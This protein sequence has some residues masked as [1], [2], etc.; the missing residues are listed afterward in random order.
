MT[1]R[2]DLAGAV[3]GLAGGLLA[4]VLVGSAL[5]W[6]RGEAV[7]ALAGGAVM[8]VNFAGL[9]WG[10]TRLVAAHPGVA[11]ASPALRALWMAVT[12]LRLALAGAALAAAL[13]A[14]AGVRGLSLSLLCLPAAV[15]AAGLRDASSARAA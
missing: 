12:G 8:L 9:E 14:G 6:G 11:P 5:A 2:R 10:A 1:G 3:Y 7:G 4:L 15:V 13:A